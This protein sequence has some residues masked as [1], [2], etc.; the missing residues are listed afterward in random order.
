MKKWMTVILAVFFLVAGCGKNPAKDPGKRVEIT[1]E[2]LKNK[3]D[4]KESFIFIVAQTT[5]ENCAQYFE[6]LDE[7]MKN[8]ALTVYVVEADAPV[9]EETFDPVWDAYFPEVERTP[10][11]VVVK[12]GVI[13]E[14]PKPAVGYLKT[15]EIDQYLKDCG[16][17]LP[18][19]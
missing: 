5:C 16:I 8:H 13:L 10:T 3:F 9:N 17:V 11:T 14:N 19:E 4:A 2:A 15:D 18:N 6:Y 7:Y 1:A 12:D